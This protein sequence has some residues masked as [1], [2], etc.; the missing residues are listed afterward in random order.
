MNPAFE[1]YKLN[2]AG[3]A[4]VQQT[5]LAFDDLLAQLSLS[6]LDGRYF[7][8]TKTY[9]EQASMFAIKGISLD[10]NNQET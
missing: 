8:L 9:L 2:A 5:R 1:S 3:M 7:S 4:K 6:V 10:P